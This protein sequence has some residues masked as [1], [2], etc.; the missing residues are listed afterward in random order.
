M[1][2]IGFRLI[3]YMNMRVALFRLDSS[4]VFCVIVVLV[5]EVGG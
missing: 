5:E 2:G 4:G 1:L 3:I